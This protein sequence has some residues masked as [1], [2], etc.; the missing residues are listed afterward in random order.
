[1]GKVFYKRK[2]LRGLKLDKGDL[3]RRLGEMNLV[4]GNI[5]QIKKIVGNPNIFKSMGVFQGLAKKEAI[6]TN[7]FAGGEKLLEVVKEFGV[8]KDHVDMSNLYC[9]NGNYN[10]KFAGLTYMGL[11]IT[12]TVPRRDYS[13]RI[14][15][16]YDSLQSSLIELHKGSGEVSSELNDA[17]FGSLAYGLLIRSNNNKPLGLDQR[18]LE[19]FILGWGLVHPLPSGGLSELGAGLIK[20]RE[21]Q[22]IVRATRKWWGEEYGK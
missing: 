19:K 2:F 8:Y 13:K 3:E 16:V 6:K 14:M 22:S 17:A 1:M 11:L 5:E 18:L 15:L 20:A 9:K 4:G 21:I 10:E 12:S 7:M